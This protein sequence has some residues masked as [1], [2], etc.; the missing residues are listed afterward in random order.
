M[1]SKQSYSDKLAQA[2]GSLSALALLPTGAQAGVIY[3]DTPLVITPD[4]GTSIEWNVDNKGG[5]EFALFGNYSYSSNPYSNPGH[6]TPTGSGG[7]TWVSGTYSYNPWTNRN[8]GIADHGLNGRGMVQASVGS[9]PRLFQNLPVGFILGPTL[10][11]GYRLT[12]G[13]VMRWVASNSSLARSAVG[14]GSGVNGYFGFKFTDGVDL[15]FGWAEINIDAPNTTYTINRWAYNDTPDGSI[16]VGQTASISIPEPSTPSLLLIGMGAAGIRA[17]RR[18]K[19][20][21]A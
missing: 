21:S 12:R 10:A 14:F 17:W 11:A 15:F 3:Y 4:L 9:D 13:S 20:A 16:K 19:Q 7:S 5:A 6:Y 8:V 18:R 1:K 2:A